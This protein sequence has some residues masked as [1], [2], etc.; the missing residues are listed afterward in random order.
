M[1][2]FSTVISLLN[3]QWGGMC[4][5]KYSPIHPAFQI[6]IIKPKI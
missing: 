4:T 3:L 1:V 2:L 6:P 5:V